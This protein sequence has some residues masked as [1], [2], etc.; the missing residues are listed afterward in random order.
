MIVHFIFFFN[1]RMRKAE[2][3]SVNLFNVN[4]EQALCQLSF[5]IKSYSA[6]STAVV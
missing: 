1:G 3:D 5:L 6:L 2:K 4:E